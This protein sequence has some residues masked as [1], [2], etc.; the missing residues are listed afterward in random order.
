MRFHVL[1]VHATREFVRVRVALFVCGANLC[2]HALFSLHATQISA[3][4]HVV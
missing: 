2:E 4:A 1:L 3:L